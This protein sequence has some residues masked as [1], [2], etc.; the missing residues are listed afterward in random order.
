MNGLRIVGNPTDKI[1]KV[2]I[3]G[4]LFP[5]FGAQTETTEYGTDLINAMEQGLDAIIP[6]EIIEWTVVSYVRDALCAWEKQGNI[7]HRALQH[8]RAGYALCAGLD[9]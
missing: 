2:A 3:V 9:W 6:G 1:R 5:G 7:Q 4:H 8:G